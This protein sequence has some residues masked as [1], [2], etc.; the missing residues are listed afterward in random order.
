MDLVEW[1]GRYGVDREE[2][3]FVLLD[4]FLPTSDGSTASTRDSAKEGHQALSGVTSSWGLAVASDRFVQ[5]IFATP[6]FPSTVAT[7]LKFSALNATRNI[8]NPFA[9][10]LEGSSLLPLSGDLEAFMPRITG[11]Q[12][13]STFRTG[14]LH[15]RI[16][17]GFVSAEAR[18]AA[19]ASAP[20]L[21]WNSANARFAKAHPFHRNMLEMR[22]NV[23]VVRPPS[24]EQIVAAFQSIVQQLSTKGHSCQ[25][26]QVLRVIHV[27]T[28]KA[29]AHTVGWTCPTRGLD[30]TAVRHDYEKEAP[31]ARCHFAGHVERCPLMQAANRKEAEDLARHATGVGRAATTTTNNIRP[32]ANNNNTSEVW[33]LAAPS[34][35]D[36]L[37]SRNRFAGLEVEGG[38]EDD[39]E[40][41][42]AGKQGEEKEQDSDSDGN[43]G[44]GIDKA[45]GDGKDDDKDDDEDDDKD[46][47]DD[48]SEGKRTKE[49]EGNDGDDVMKDGAEEEDEGRAT[50]VEEEVDR[51]R[52]GT[53][54]QHHDHRRRPNDDHHGF[55]RVDSS[56]SLVA[57]TISGDVGK[58]KEAII[59]AQLDAEEPLVRHQF[60][61]WGQEDGQLRF[62]NIRGTAPARSEQVKGRAGKEVAGQGKRVTRS[63]SAAA[64][65]Q[66]EG[67]K[68]KAEKGKGVEEEKRWSD[69]EPKDDI[70]PEFPLFE[71]NT[72][73]KSTWNVRR[74]MGI[75]EKRRDI[76]TYL[77]TF[78]ASAILLQEHFIKPELWQCIKD[79]YEGKAFISKHCLTLI[80][81]DSPLIDAEILR[82]HSALDGR[83]LV[84]S[85]RLRG[86]I[87]ILEINNLYA[88]VDT[89]QRLTF[90][91][92]LH[93]HRTQ[94]THLRLLGGDL[95]D[96]PLRRSIAEPRPQHRP[97]ATKRLVQASTIYDHP[98][99]LSDHRPV[100]IVLVLS[101]ERGDAAQPNN[102]LPTTSNQLHR[103]NAATFKTAA[104][105]GML[106][107]GWKE[108]VGRN[109]W[110]SSR[111]CWG[112]ARRRVGSWR[113]GSIGSGWS[114]WPV[115]VGRVQDLEALPVMGDEETAEWTRTTEELRRAVNE[116]ARQLSDPSPRTR[117][118]YRGTTVAAALRLP[119]GELTHDIDVALDHTQA[120]FQRLYNL[121]PRDR[122]HVERLRDD[123]LAPIRAAAHLRRPEL[124]P[125]F[126]RRL[127]EAHI[128]LLQQPIT[129]D[130][131][132]AAIATTHPGRSPGP[133]GVPYELYH[134][135]PRAWAKALSR[136]FNAMTERGSLSPRQG[137]GLVR[138]LFKHH[139]IG[140]DRAELS[141]YRPITLRECDYKLF[142]KVYVARLN[143]VLPDLLPPQQ[144]GFVKGRRSA[145]ASFHL[146]LLI[147]ELGARGT[148]FPDAALLSLDQSSAY[149]LVEHEWIF[150]IFDALGAPAA[151]QRVLRMLYSG[152]ST[153]ARYIINGF[154]T[155]PVRLTC[156]LGQGDPASSS[157][158]DVVFQPF[159]DALHRRGIALNL[160]LPTIHPYPQSRAI[161]SLA[162]ADDV[163]VAVAGSES[164]T[165][166]DDLALDWRLATNGRLNTDKTVVLPIGCRWEA[167]DRP[168]VVKAEGESLEWIGLSFDPTGNTELANVNLVA[169]LEAVLDSARDRGLTHHTRAFYVNRY[170]I[171]KILHILSADIP[172][173]EVVK[174]LDRILVDF[175]RGGKRR[176]CYGKDVVFTPRFKGGLGV[177]RMQDVVDSVAA[178]VW[179]VLLGGSDA[180]WQGLARAAIVRAHPAPDFDLA[181]DAWPCDYTPIRTDLH[182]RWQAVLKVPSTHN[183]QVKPRTLTLA[184]LLALP[185]KLHTLHYLPGAPAVS[186]S[187]YD[188][189]YAAF[190]NYAKVADLFRRELY[191]GGGFHLWTPPTDVVVSNSEYDQRGRPQREHIVAWYRHA[192]NR[193]RFTPIA[194]PV[195]AVRING[196]PRV[197]PRSEVRPTTPLESIL[198]HPIDPPQRLPRPALPDQSTQYNLLSMDRPYTIRRVRR[199]LNAKAFTDTI[200]FRDSLQPDD[201]KGFWKGVNSKALTAR[202]R[203]VWFK[204]VRNFT[205]T[206]SLQFHQKHDDSPACLVCGAPKDD[207]E[208]YFF[209]CVDSGN[210]WIA[211]RSVLCDALGLDTID[212]THYTAVQRMFGLPKLKASLFELQQ[213]RLQEVEEGA[214]R[215]I[216][217]GRSE[218]G[219]GEKG[220][221]GIPAQPEELGGGEGS[222]GWVRLSPTTT[223]HTHQ[224]LVT[225]FS[226]TVH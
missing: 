208:H 118:R 186:R 14:V 90:F 15:H 84:T 140:A 144:H 180:I 136:A 135:A 159:L 134:T 160:S 209:D 178:R 23:G 221:R 204:L 29:Y 126:L 33:P 45:G 161:T 104:F 66:V 102:S 115:L 182:P 109:R 143:H 68:A 49:D 26:V 37:E 96:C 83:I 201:L 69:H 5:A 88:P 142:T 38:Q 165:L 51:N 41:E 74:C 32:T 67:A 92:K 146:R 131:V 50:E 86:D 145:D 173:L 46:E 197:R 97:Q 174:E 57:S 153:T 156:G 171:P 217:R 124:G 1:N 112:T 91:D 162:F 207:R 216:L 203:E 172:P 149:D 164:L 99:D 154:L 17:V 11:L 25:L 150:A 166:L 21:V 27:D 2:G 200:G 34:G 202:E 169:R 85:F 65:M 181:T 10:A 80:P 141:S 199:V 79:E 6:D 42:D 176:S 93:F 185:I 133:S 210:V 111:W 179:D 73:A 4:R 193:L 77:S 31:C 48:S 184:N 12:H 189:D 123:F 175:V 24:K 137:Q 3:S 213:P 40:E 206:R 30:V 110:G 58:K 28:A 191:P 119:N 9:N 218:K 47:Q 63:M 103:I 198:P 105:Q 107:D 82:T 148:E 215:V 61:E 116:R 127:S 226:P 18:D 225:S 22:I 35:T 81:A 89:K 163:V 121:E 64:A 117:N 151:F 101:D 152:D 224:I 168:L 75:P 20:M 195:A 157:V 223:T 76:Y 62:I 72:T 122:D 192:I 70:L 167:G 44:A 138:L 43:A 170:A 222:R 39:V 132:V 78:K 220:R 56:E 95:N 55:P 100:S 59:N 113:G 13:S 71:D 106:E 53:G 87:R 205:P 98:K 147:E 158:W 108:R 219:G 8:I 187:P 190:A 16:T 120:H 139:K 7:A 60:A 212:N 214:R 36:Q 196:P 52:G 130:E 128:E 19:L 54:R 129:E 183:A 155:P 125:L 114:G 177:M 94:S 188:A 194:Q 211:A